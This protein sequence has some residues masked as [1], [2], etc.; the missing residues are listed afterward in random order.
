MKGGMIIRLIDIVLIILFGF[1]GISDIQIKRQIKLAGKPLEQ[2]ESDEEPKE[3]VQLFV[4]IHS[5]DR[6][7]LKVDETIF[8]EVNHIK[9]LRRALLDQRREAFNAGKNFL[10]IIDPL[11]EST[12]QLMVDVYDLCEKEKINKSIDFQLSESS[13]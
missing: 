1:I 5:K 10:V 3:T 7:E 11:E 12:I 13:S 2:P 4:L 8:L 9:S 6:F